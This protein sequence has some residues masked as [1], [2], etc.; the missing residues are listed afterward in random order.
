MITGLEKITAAAA[1]LGQVAMVATSIKSIWSALND[2]D[3]SWGEKFTTIAMGLSMII[4]SLLG[5]FKS[6]NTV[7]GGH[8][9]TVISA[10]I[11]Q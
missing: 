3:M 10:G 11:A 2:E 6:L 8:I 9:T 1:G 5:A 7:M 4:P